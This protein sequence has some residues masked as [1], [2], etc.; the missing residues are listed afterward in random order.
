VGVIPISWDGS[1][2]AF[3]TGYV[4]LQPGELGR[5]SFEYDVRMLTRGVKRGGFDYE[6][7]RRLEKAIRELHFDRLRIDLYPTANPGRSMQIRLAGVTTSPEVHAPVVLEINVNAPLDRFVK[8]G[9]NP[10]KP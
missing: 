10:V 8:W 3:G 6:I 9:T 4:E 1:Q 5:V 7:R 2:V